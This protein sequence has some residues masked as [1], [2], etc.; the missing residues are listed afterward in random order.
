MPNKKLEVTRTVDFPLA[1]KTAFELTDSK[2][3][4]FAKFM[5]RDGGG[6]WRLTTQQQNMTTDIVTQSAAFFNM[7]VSKFIALGE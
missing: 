5:N 6:V 7:T 1:F 2:K 3:T 4:D